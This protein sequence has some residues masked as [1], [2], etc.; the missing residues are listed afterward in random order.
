M[1][2]SQPRR[3]RDLV[4]RYQVRIYRLSY[5]YTLERGLTSTT[6]R[7]RIHTR[8]PCILSGMY[9]RVSF[10]W[11]TRE[12]NAAPSLAIMYVS[13]IRTN[14]ARIQH[15]IQQRWDFCHRLCTLQKCTKNSHLLIVRT[16]TINQV[17]SCTASCSCTSAIRWKAQYF[18]RTLQICATRKI[19]V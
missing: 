2:A 8:P 12:R 1:A 7:V 19:A 9:P 10:Q 15:T 6:V 18:V 5:R 16:R 17:H 3:G 11:S 14:N 13:C 4:A